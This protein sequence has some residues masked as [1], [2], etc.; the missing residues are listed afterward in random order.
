MQSTSSNFNPLTSFS[1]SKNPSETLTSRQGSFSHAAP[2]R[3][4]FPTTS[5]CKSTSTTPNPWTPTTLMTSETLIPPTNSACSS[6]RFVAAL[7]AGAMTGQTALLHTP[8]RRLAAAT[9]AGFITPGRCVRSIGAG[10]AA[11]AM[12]VSSLMVCSSAG[13]TLQG[14]EPRLA[15]MG[16]IASEKFAFSLTPLAN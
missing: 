2:Q 5:S 1:P 8:A 3:T 7:V 6:S 14:I 9:L 4:C 13:C 10:S 12:H 11:A 16:R 15:R